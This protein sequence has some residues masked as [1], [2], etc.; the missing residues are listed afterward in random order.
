MGCY[1]TFDVYVASN[2]QQHNPH[3]RIVIDDPPKLQLISL[4]PYNLCPTRVK[5]STYVDKTTFVSK[6]TIVNT[7]I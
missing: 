3:N 7:W 1:C 5:M 2:T 6:K 4:P